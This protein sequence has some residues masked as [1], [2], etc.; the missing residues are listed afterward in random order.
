LLGLISVFY[1]REIE[2][3]R[4]KSNRF[5][6]VAYDEGDMHQG[7]IHVWQAI[8]DSLQAISFTLYWST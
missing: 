4:I 1:Q 5:I 2:L 3:L 7:L 6:V 8:T